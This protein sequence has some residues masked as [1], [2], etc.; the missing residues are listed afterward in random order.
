MIKIRTITVS[1][2]HAHPN[3]VLEKRYRVEKVTD[4]TEYGPH[5]YLSLQQVDELCAANSWK[6]YIVPVPAKD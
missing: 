4:T 2:P 1:F 3:S 5:D 6:V